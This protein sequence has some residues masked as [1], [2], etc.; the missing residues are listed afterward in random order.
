MTIPATLAL[1]QAVVAA[2]RA[3]AGLQALIGQRVY[4]HIPEREQFPYVSLRDQVR[5]YDT[6]TERGKEHTLQLN[7]WSRAE[8]SKEAELV[9]HGLERVLRDL[10]PRALTDHTLINLD[11]EMATV[12]RDEGGQ[13]YFG[14]VRARAVTEE[15]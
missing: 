2:L 11:V 15:V 1:R 8:G 14:Y 3:D 4:D 7:A 12:V 5:A 6:T 10:S 9:L 13:T